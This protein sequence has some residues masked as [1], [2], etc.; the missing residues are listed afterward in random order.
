MGQPR[1][2]VA[3][4]VGRQAD[5]APDR[6]ALEFPGAEIDFGTLDE[7]AARCAGALGSL[8]VG[9]GD[10]VGVLMSNRPEY[11][12][13]LLACG[14]LGAILVPLSIHLT[15]TE[16]GFMATDSGM[17]VL[18][19][20]SAFSET[21]KAFS[22][23]TEIQRALVIGD[24][25]DL[26]YE[27]AVASAGSVPV[28]DLSGDTV[29]AIFYTSGTTGLPKGAMLTHSNFFW[30]NL[31]MVLA[32]DITRDER[33]L[34]VLPLFH[35]G[36]WNVNT[37]SVWLKGGRVVLEPSFEPSRVLSLIDDGKVTSVMG[38]P[39]IYQRLAEHSLFNKADLSGLK[40]CVCGGAPL[41]VSLINRYHER[42]V[43]FTQGYGLT[44]AAPN[45]LF[46]PPEMSIEKAGAAGRPY[47]FADVDIFDDDDHPVEAGGSGEIVV[48]GPSVMKGYWRRPEETARALRGSWLR[49]GDVG[50]IDEDG[51][52]FVVDRVKDMFISGGENVYPA[53]V[54]KALVGHPDVAEAAVIGVADERW[55]ETGRAVVVLRPEASVDGDDLTAFLVEHIAKFKVPSSFVFV[56]SLPRNATGKLLKSQIRDEHGD[57]T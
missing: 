8:G 2:N 21:V 49:T 11:V 24:G 33:S 36:G 54:E 16:L 32:L 48:R 30:T 57:A 52:I 17:R 35:V 38:V 55:G 50:R 25:D 28:Q 46:L 43:P 7:R 20:E 37:L 47:F 9:P 39:T 10:R 18:V 5:L 27:A 41:P 12:D 51:Y 22:P 4:W 42:G 14:R 56:D 13:V 45:C 26:S 34:V 1:N 19:Y 44:E 40:W 6:V 53:E 29:L 15:P 31:N 3:Y 23:S